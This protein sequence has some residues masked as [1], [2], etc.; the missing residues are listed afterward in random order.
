[1]LVRDCAIR[2]TGSDEKLSPRASKALIVAAKRFGPVCVSG[3]SD[4]SIQ[5]RGRRERDR[6][7][8]GANMAGSSLHD[9]EGCV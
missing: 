6:R 3:P 1:M 9:E 7:N 8:W 4:E 2:M 5:A